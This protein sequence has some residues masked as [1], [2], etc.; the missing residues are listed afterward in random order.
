MSRH[1]HL[2]SG[3]FLFVAD[4]E[5]A[6]D[7]AELRR[8]FWR[9]RGRRHR[10]RHLFGEIEDIGGLILHLRHRFGIRSLGFVEARLGRRHARWRR[11]RCLR[12]R[13]GP[14][15]RGRRRGLRRLR[16]ARRGFVGVVVGD[17]TAYGG[18]NFL[19]RRFLRFRRLRHPRIL[20]RSLSHP[21][22]DRRKAL[23]FGRRGDGKSS[24]ASMKR[25]RR[26]CHAK[27]RRQ[28]TICG[29]CATA[30]PIARQPRQA[31]RTLAAV[32]DTDADPGIA[33]LLI[34]HLR[35]VDRHV[36]AEPRHRQPADRRQ[37]RV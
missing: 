3:S 16:R 30:S 1:G 6:V 14:G 35:I 25:H 10:C 7:G 17:D 32:G 26:L 11:G 22:I 24:A 18:E 2:R 21:N 15:G 4:V 28:T 29:L 34:V 23:P 8:G 37:Q 5:T 31:P 33:H 20:A 36:E 9:R 27:N 13:C 19:H 12:R